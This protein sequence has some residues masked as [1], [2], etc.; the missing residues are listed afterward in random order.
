M[1]AVD[2]SKCHSEK[3]SQQI[4]CDQAVWPHWFIFNYFKIAEPWLKCWC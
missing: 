4:R 1:T 3:T 2:L